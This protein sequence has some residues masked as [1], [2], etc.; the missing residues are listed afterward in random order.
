LGMKVG[1]HHCI[2]RLHILLCSKISSSIWFLLDIRSDSLDLGL[3]VVVG[4][5]D[6]HSV[7]QRMFFLMDIRKYLCIRRWF[8]MIFLCS[9]ECMVLFEGPSTI[10][11][12]LMRVSELLKIFWRTF[13]HD[14]NFLVRFF[15]RNLGM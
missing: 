8:R 11:Y 4:V 15:K 6:R 3:E 10:R 7:R 13:I 1:N 12:L 2:L 14:R 5:V 9:L